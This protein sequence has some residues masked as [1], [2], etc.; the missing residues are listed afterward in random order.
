MADFEEEIRRLRAKIAA[1]DRLERSLVRT[2][3]R[4]EGGSGV[5]AVRVAIANLA[6]PRRALDQAAL[7]LEIDDGLLAN[8]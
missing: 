5:A 1:L 6:E 2:V 4:L 7:E 8:L 3:G